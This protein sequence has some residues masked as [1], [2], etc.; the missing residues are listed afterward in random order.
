MTLTPEIPK[1]KAVYWQGLKPGMVF[2]GGVTVNG[3]VPYEL[4]GYPC[5]SPSLLA[6]LKRRY[7]FLDGRRVLVL[8]PGILDGAEISKALARAEE[9]V[10]AANSLRSAVLEGRAE[11]LGA[12]SESIPALESSLVEKPGLILDHWASGAARFAAPGEAPSL[13][14]E[15]TAKIAMAD[16]LS[17][18]L[19]ER[20]GFPDSGPF[21]LHVVVDASYSMKASGRD[22]LALGALSLFSAHLPKLYPEAT[23]LYHAFS[24]DSVELRPPF[25]SL[26]LSRG[27]TRYERFVRK[28]LHAREKGRPCAVLLFTD[29]VPSDLK[30]AREHLARF[31][32]LGIDYFQIVLSI[33]EEGFARADPSAKLLDGY[34]KPGSSAIAAPLEK[35][36]QAAE[37]RRVRDEF[38]SLAMEAGGN[39]AI[40]TVDRALGVIAVEAFDRWLGAISLA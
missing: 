38:T 4:R 2:A 5:L 22:E 25:A 6:E 9:G 18:R 26:P 21:E 12:G 1:L 30:A 29:G 23:I 27:E 33:P 13:L 7:S 19:A 32:R 40:L 36:E 35:E 28:V 31:K 11:L 16:I 24:D 34:L 8:E 17:G 3:A 10:D 39:Q 37:A 14:R 20:F 15:I